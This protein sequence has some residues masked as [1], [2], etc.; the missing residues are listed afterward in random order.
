MLR[1]DFQVQTNTDQFAIARLHIT[2]T[3]GKEYG[4][5]DEATYLAEFSIIE[6]E[7]LTMRS[8]SFTFRRKEFNVFAIVKHALSTLSEEELK[9]NGKAGPTDLARGLTS[10]L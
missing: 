5:E 4:D 6:G 10:S 8:R 3:S 9:L 7:E 2:N 1:I